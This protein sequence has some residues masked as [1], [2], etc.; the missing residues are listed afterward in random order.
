MRFQTVA[1]RGQKIR[2]SAFSDP[3]F[4]IPAITVTATGRIL[5]AYDVRSDWRDLPADF[6]I[7]FRY[8]D[9]KG[10]TWSEPALLR[11][12]TPGHGF[13]DAS[14]LTNPETGTILCWY[15]GSTGES[16]FSARAGRPGLELWL[17][18]SDD[19]GLTWTHRDYSSLRPNQVAGMFTSSGNGAITGEGAL[20]QT[21]VARID[22]RN[23]AICASSVDN[24]E[25]WTMGEPVGPDCDENKVVALDDGT[26]LMHARA[27]PARRQGF[28]ADLG[29]TFTP[30]VPVALL[31]DPACNGGLARIGR[32]L[33]ASMCD[34][35][36]HRTRLS[37]HVSSDEARSW[38]A[39]ILIDDGAAAYSALVVIDDDTLGL[40][41]EADDY[42][43][44]VFTSLSVS[45]LMACVKDEQS[46]SLKHI[47]HGSPGWAK[48]PVVNEHNN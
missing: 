29:K 5:V 17:A 19:D 12:H 44:I 37:V 14:L 35:A 41:W 45:E 15:V 20:L 4:R 18:T 3:I 42:Q 7:V 33:F 21:F 26:I 48:P 43:S 10:E 6:D 24:G 28:S 13:G 25:T 31:Q 27:T 38:S 30:L 39:P 34:D 23:Y 40:V 22:D 11:S 47:R 32:L 36:V 8:S 1:E 2:G 46:R 9:D 16:Y